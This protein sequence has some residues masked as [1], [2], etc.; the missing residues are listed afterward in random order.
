MFVYQSWLKY[1]HYLFAHGR[2]RWKYSLHSHLMSILSCL[3]LD[4]S[5]VHTVRTEWHSADWDRRHCCKTERVCA[6]KRHENHLRVQYSNLRS[7]S[8]F[9]VASMA[10]K[11]WKY[12]VSY[13]I[14]EFQNSSGRS[15]TSL[16]NV[17][18]KNCQSICNSSYQ[19]EARSF[20]GDTYILQI[21]HYRLECRK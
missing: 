14:K 9:V 16:R 18:M 1:I 8:V 21:Q 2:A 19:R 4:S 7:D 17:C 3:L 20:T 15:C 5:V 10:A 11:F 12:V 6:V 13:T